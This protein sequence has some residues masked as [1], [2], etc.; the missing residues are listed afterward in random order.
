MSDVRLSWTLP[1]VTSRQRP[2]DHVRIELRADASL[3][4]TEQDQVPASD[5]QELLLADVAPGDWFYRATVVDID[6]E[7]GSPEG[8]TASLGFDAP[9]SVTG[10]TATVE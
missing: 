2:I 10:L 6:G 7:E 9:D 8:T 5:P 3:P 4:W 1:V